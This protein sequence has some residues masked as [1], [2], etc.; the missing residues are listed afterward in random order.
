MMHVFMIQLLHICIYISLI[1]DLDACTYYATVSYM[2]VSMMHI[3]H[4]AC[5]HVHSMQLRMKHVKNGDKR[6]NGQKAEF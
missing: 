5:T 2:H 4:D 3:S 6:M 1:Q